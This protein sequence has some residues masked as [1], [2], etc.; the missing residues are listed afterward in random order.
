MRL[1]TW[2][3][4]RFL[5][6]ITLFIF[7]AA[8][9]LLV[10]LFVADPLSDDPPIAD[11][12]TSPEL[13]E[14]LATAEHEVQTAQLGK[15]EPIGL[16]LPTQ[17]GFASAPLR[18]LGLRPLEDYATRLSE[19]ILEFTSSQYLAQPH[20]LYCL[21]RIY[22]VPFERSRTHP[23]TECQPISKDVREAVFS[24]L[25][26]NEIGITARL[27][28]VSFSGANEAYYDKAEFINGFGVVYSL[29]ASEIKVAEVNSTLVTARNG[30]PETHTGTYLF[31]LAPVPTGETQLLTR[32]IEGEGCSLAMKHMFDTFEQLANPSYQTDTVLNSKRALEGEFTDRPIIALRH[33]LDR[34]F[35]A[36]RMMAAIEEH[37]GLS[38]TYYVNFAAGFSGLITKGAYYPN[39]SLIN[40]L[41]ILRDRGH[42]VGFH[43]DLMFYELVF[44]VPM[45]E[46][47][48]TYIEPLRRLGFQF[49]SVSGNGSE[50]AYLLGT[51]NE[52]IFKDF[53][54][55]GRFAR[56]QVEPENA[57]K[58]RRLGIDGVVHYERNGV[59]QEIILPDKT[60]SDWGFELDAY[61]LYAYRQRDVTSIGE[62]SDV[63]ETKSQFAS[64][65]SDLSPGSVTSV[66]MHPGDWLYCNT[67]ADAFL[68]ITHLEYFAPYNV[69]PQRP[70]L[71]ALYPYLDK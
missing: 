17:N 11:A 45:V 61:H 64:R 60:L 34:S 8:L 16:V 32:G 31:I 10:F 19:A 36:A 14:G 27:G 13:I 59:K 1:R 5:V 71:S 21:G 39:P 51:E 9:S 15:L 54:I 44:G 30:E 69:R 53:R 58:E 20:Y 62:V 18:W 7:F 25:A 26:N 2:N 12:V 50:Y 29:N 33:D 3:S 43:N 35:L 65:L 49:S 48:Q 63:S 68:D 38:S 4:L 46:W 22:V 40:L 52:Y 28:T 41:R 42:E 37:Y 70:P 67:E 57:F 23:R 55:G 66:L 47:F 6:T 24:A 56:S